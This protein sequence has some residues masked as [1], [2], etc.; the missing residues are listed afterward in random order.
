MKDLGHAKQILGMT[1]TRHRDSKKLYLSQ[2]KYIKK[3]LQR[4]N[5]DGAK[6]V[7]SPLAPHFKLSTK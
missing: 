3:V 5:M 4:F 6:P 7:A 2:E 1:I